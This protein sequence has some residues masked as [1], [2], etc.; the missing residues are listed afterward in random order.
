[1]SS[2]IFKLNHDVAV[3]APLHDQPA[4]LAIAFGEPF[5]DSPE[6]REHQ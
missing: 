2:S 6:V 5:S 4:L 1:M 3:L